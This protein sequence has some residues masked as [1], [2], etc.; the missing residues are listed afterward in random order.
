MTSIPERQFACDAMLGGLARWLP[1]AGY[2]AYWQQRIADQELV[3]LC[4]RE[5]RTMLPLNTKLFLCRVLRDNLLPALL[6][7][8]RRTPGEQLA[9]ILATFKLPLRPPRSMSCG[10]AWPKCPRQRFAIGCLLA[11]IP[12]RINTARRRALDGSQDVP[13]HR[14]HRAPPGQN[15]SVA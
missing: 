13:T 3:R 2:E 1:A 5:G 9:H 7:P 14:Q 15:R 6:V 4:Q 12:G 8:L 11:H 10:G